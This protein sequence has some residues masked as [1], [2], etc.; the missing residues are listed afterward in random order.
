MNMYERIMGHGSVIAKGIWIKYYSSVFLYIDSVR[1]G[2][3]LTLN[4]YLINMSFR[5]PSSK[6]V[7][8][9]L[10]ENYTMII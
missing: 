10:S 6:F 4:V 2:F 7:I 3:M 1:N 8:T 9:L 5:C